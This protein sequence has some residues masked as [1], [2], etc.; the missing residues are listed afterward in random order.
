VF[1]AY[2][3]NQIYY[4]NVVK[5]LKILNDR[6]LYESVDYNVWDKGY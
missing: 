1:G 2:N 6:L 4:N 3:H 5:N